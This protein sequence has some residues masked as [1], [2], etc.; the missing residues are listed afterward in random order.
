MMM[1][2]DIKMQQPSSAVG[3]IST[4]RQWY[5]RCSLAAAGAA[6]TAF[7]RSAAAERLVEYQGEANGGASRS[8][9]ADNSNVVFVQDHYYI[10]GT[11]P[12]FIPPG[13]TSYPEKLPFVPSKQRVEALAKYR[14]R[15]QRGI[16]L[17]ASLRGEIE[18]GRYPAVLG[19]EAPEYSIRP[20]GLLAAGFLGSETTVNNELY[21]AR[22]YINEIFL[23]IND[24]KAA[25]SKEAALA[26]HSN[27]IKAL[28]SLLGMLN[29]AITSKVG[30]PFELLSSSSSSPT[31]PPETATGS[32][33]QEST[34]AV[35][36]S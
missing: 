14:P 10:F 19:A 9:R 16:D 35:Q 6:M 7:P 12:P 22:W 1:S 13:D 24:I 25:P 17:L 36:E 2:A 11:A 21:L 28:N 18:A 30:D 31:P 3:S 33:T 4:R 26:S 32:A 34:V 15:V 20:F 5:Q 27:A 8:R 29:R 23:D